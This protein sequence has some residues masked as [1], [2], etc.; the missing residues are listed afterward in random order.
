[1]LMLM[2][3]Y[4]SL[5]LSIK[6]T[7][8]VRIPIM[9]IDTTH[10]THTSPKQPESAWKRGWDLLWAPE[11]EGPVLAD[12]TYKPEDENNGDTFPRFN[13]DRFDI[14]GQITNSPTDKMRTLARK[15]PIQQLSDE[16]IDNSHK[17]FNGYPRLKQ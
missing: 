3:V 4:L 16:W 8:A 7:F 9:D 6:Q 15:L 17:K 5:N 11:E 2:F 14:L 13:P 1:M 12:F 10:P